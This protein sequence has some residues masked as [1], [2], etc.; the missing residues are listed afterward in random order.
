MRIFKLAIYL[1]VLA[2]PKMI[3][4]QVTAIKAGIL[5]DP[6]SGLSSKS[7]IVLVEGQLIKTVASEV[8]IPEGAEVIDLSG[9]SVLPGLFDAHTHLCTDVAIDASWKGRITERL[10]SYIL[11]TSTAYRALTGGAKSA[12]MLQSGFTTVR[13]VGNAGNYADTDLRRA[14]ENGLIKGPTIINAGRIIAPFG[15]Q[16]HLHAERPELGVPEYLH[17][18]T[19]DELQN[20][21][22][23]NIHFGAKVIKVVVDSQPY[24]YSEDDLRFI[25]EEAGRAGIKVA[26]HCHTA[27][28]A[29]NAIKAGVA[30]IEHG[31]KM[32]DDI[33]VLAK[34]N[35]VVLVGTEMPI[36]LLELF[37]S[38]ARYPILI[39]RL[40][41][42]HR[43]GVTL[44]YGSDALYEVGNRSR[45]EMALAN[46]ES[47][48]EAGIP[49]LATLRAMTTNAA[50]LLG[51]EKERGAIKSGLAAD[52][53][54]VRGNPLEDAYSLREV[55]FV[56]KNGKI[57]K[58]PQ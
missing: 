34:N 11:Q 33:L 50:K 1:F 45:G 12:S 19:R 3:Y 37:G 28:A 10:T 15:G 54:A 38:E 51:V 52:L 58:E 57:V 53:I 49:P 7:Q 32:S 13:D 18:D 46:L 40:R 9:F 55:V 42:A 8:N 27:Q 26:A 29:M 36:W 4:P 24:I 16:L 39:D 35:G 44:V 20:A 22:R 41:R 56:M 21:I 30:S 23:E 14:V 31:T 47:W 5:I 2:V 6:A 43:L 25:V 48:Q 17:A